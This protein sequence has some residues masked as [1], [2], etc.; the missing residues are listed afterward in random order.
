MELDWLIFPS[1]DTSY[2]H[3]KINGEL[4]FIPKIQNIVE[5]KSQDNY[6]FNDNENNDFNKDIK[7]DNLGIS[8]N[9]IIANFIIIFFS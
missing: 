4:I 9:E 3:D 1:P 8:N 6:N 2:S 5:N 7:N